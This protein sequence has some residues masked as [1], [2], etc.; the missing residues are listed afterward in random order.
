M[1]GLDCRRAVCK[2]TSGV[3][4]S[5]KR[6]TTF[7]LKES[8][9]MVPTR[10]PFVPLDL[11]SFAG[12]NYTG[13]DEPLEFTMR[14]GVVHIHR[15][16]GRLNLVLAARLIP[17]VLVEP[18]AIF[19]DWKDLSRRGFPRNLMYTKHFAGPEVAVDG[20]RIPIP[21]SNAVFGVIADSDLEVIDFDWFEGDRNR[22]GFPSGY[23]NPE[24]MGEGLWTP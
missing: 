13:A 15:A 8:A 10:R 24:I 20:L 6:A 23:D 12:K 19:S 9:H 17:L 2:L 5:A 4:A 3:R 11:V 16:M 22:P 1:A 18:D 7:L 21:N 14:E